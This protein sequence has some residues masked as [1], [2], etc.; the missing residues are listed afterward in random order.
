MVNNFH[1]RCLII[2]DDIKNEIA[3]NSL[4]MCVDTAAIKRSNGAQIELRH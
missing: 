2:L 4:G 3:N 1:N